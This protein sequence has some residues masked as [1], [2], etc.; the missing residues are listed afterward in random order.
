MAYP[1]QYEGATFVELPDYDAEGDTAMSDDE[2]PVLEVHVGDRPGP[3]QGEAYM[4]QGNSQ[5]LE[6]S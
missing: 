6:G 3:Y 4:F 1:V 5:E 2:T